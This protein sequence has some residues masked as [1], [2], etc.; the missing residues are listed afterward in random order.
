V[1]T[2]NSYTEL[3]NWGTPIN[4]INQEKDK[5]EEHTD[6]DTIVVEVEEKERDNITVA[7]A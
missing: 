6:N 3:P 1:L 7:P 4:T 5:V 2:R